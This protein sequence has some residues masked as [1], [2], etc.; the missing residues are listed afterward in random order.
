MIKKIERNQGNSIGVM[1]QHYNIYTK[2]K[3][4]KKQDKQD[5]F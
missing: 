1:L 3:E 2:E 5:R 4:E